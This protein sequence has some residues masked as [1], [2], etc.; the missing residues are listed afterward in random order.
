MAGIEDRDTF[1]FIVA[2]AGAAGSVVAARLSEMHGVTVA[3]IEAGPR[4]T[5]PWIH[6]PLGFGKVVPNPKLNWGYETEPEPE[7]YGRRV[8][9]P[10]GKVLGGSGSINGLVFLRGAP[11]DFDDWQQLGARG[12]AYRDV[13]PYFKRIEHQT[14]GADEFHG[15]DGPV[16]VSDIE[17]SPAG[18]AWIEACRSLGYPANRDFNGATIE[19]V[20]AVQLNVHKGRRSTTAVEYLKPRLTAGNIA[21]L[22]ET[23]VRR[24]LLEG[25][26][27]VGIE[28]HG[29]SG[30]K[31]LKARRE[32][33]VS[34]GSI[35]SPQLL[36]VSGI[37][38]GDELRAAGVTPLHELAGVGKNLQDHFLTRMAYKSR[39]PTTLNDIMRNPVKMAKM[40]LDY[41]A[42]RKGPM[43]IGAT[44]AT[45][46]ARVDKEVREP[47]LQLQFANFS[48]DNMQAGLH[49]HSGFMWNFCVCRPTSRGEITL[50]SAHPQAKPLI[51]ANYISTEHDRRLMLEGFRISRRIAEAPAMRAVIEDEFQPGPRVQTDEEAL[52]YIRKVGGTVYHPSGTCRMGED[53]RA[54]V[55][56]ELRVRGLEGLAV[57]DASV[58]PQVPTPNIH[59]ATIMIAEKA[60]DHIKA[61]NRG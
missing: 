22:V 12:W 3:V 15:T 41:V 52:D 33:I 32:I 9:W 13:L 37:G 20:G 36:M 31:V 49:K 8:G 11:G 29:K 60:S 43:T 48:W 23:Q 4:D 40:G 42:L 46:F 14:R 30:I 39:T 1:D 2:G 55:D 21:L 57:V 50:A 54:V 19:G 51:R 35:N 25:K 17:V 61:R 16:W 18:K 45:L 7:L 38:K 5:N 59:A 10:R 47:E 26:R 6:V 24:I 27:A 34:G 56:P 44:E 58:M 28:V 53:D